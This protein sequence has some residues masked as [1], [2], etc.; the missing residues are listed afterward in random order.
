MLS[1]DIEKDNE[2]ASFYLRSLH[3]KKSIR[4]TKS[5]QGT[6]FLEALALVGGLLSTLMGVG[7]LFY[8]HYQKFNMNLE[9][10]NE[11]FGFHSPN[12]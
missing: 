12:K 4:L 6:K 7:T 5:S 10:V 3:D 9:L 2:L 1:R 8:S 11:V